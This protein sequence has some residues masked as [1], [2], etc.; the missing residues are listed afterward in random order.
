MKLNYNKIKF[1][2]LIFRLTI[3]ALILIGIFAPT[4]NTFGGQFW[5]FTIQTNM[6]IL[7]SM[8]LLVF[9][10]ILNILKVS[11]N[12][13]TQ[14]WFIIFRMLSTFFISITCL[15]YCFILAPMVVVTNN[16]INVSLSYRDIFFH[17]FVP[18]LANIDFF[19]TSPKII[20]SFKSVFLFLI[21]PII[22]V[23]AIFARVFLGGK[24]FAG[25]SV[26]PYFF[27]D[28]TFYNQGW[29]MVLFYLILLLIAIFLLALLYIYFNNS[30][31]KKNDS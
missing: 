19:F 12:I 21:Y 11:N 22:Y 29:F 17:I 16:L 3:I 14:K 4:E 15:V 27:I 9:S 24:T 31:L 30:L 26:Y 28:P 7:F 1:L 8:L 5:F 2:I 20:L 13:H 23:I 10:Q 6:L 25:G 18:L